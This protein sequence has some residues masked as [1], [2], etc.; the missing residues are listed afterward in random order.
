MPL[1]NI[2]QYAELRA[3]GTVSH[4]ERQQLLEEHRKQLKAHLDTQLSHLQALDRK[5]EWYKAQ[6][7]H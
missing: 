5:I 1:G 2:L 3:C 4:S 6:E 7:I